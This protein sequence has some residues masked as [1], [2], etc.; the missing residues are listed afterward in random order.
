MVDVETASGAELNATRHNDGP[1]LRRGSRLP[2]G[3]ALVGGLLVALA[4]IGAIVLSGSSEDAAI[5]VVVAAKTIEAG[6]PLNAEVLEVV[7]MVLPEE[8]VHNTFGQVDSLKGTVARSHLEPGDILQRGGTI[9]ATAAQ[10]L[11]APTREV[12][13][14]LDADRVVDG[15]LENGDRIDVLATYGTGSGAY[16]VVVLTDAAVLAVRNLD[17]S[18]GA[19]RSVVLTLALESRADTVALAHAS[20][21]ANVTV[22]RTTTA[23]RD[24]EVLEPFRPQSGHEVTP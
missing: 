12:S 23:E 7:H 15:N 22:V 3:R 6:T 20:D 18:L 9:A 4:T 2:S 13:L 5:S 19:S 10:R 16:T 14:R 11:A 17:S 1:Q 21:V 24:V 8:L